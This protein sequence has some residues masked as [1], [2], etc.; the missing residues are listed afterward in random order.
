MSMDYKKCITG[1]E[2][3]NRPHSSMV[4]SIVADPY[5][6]GSGSVGSKSF[7]NQAKIVRKK[8]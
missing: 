7:Y 1:L 5:P 6:D 2:Q 3:G 4:T 8:P